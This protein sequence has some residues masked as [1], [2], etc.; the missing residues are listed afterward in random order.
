MSVNLVDGPHTLLYS[1][2]HED[3]QLPIVTKEEHRLGL[4]FQLEF[5]DIQGVELVAQ[6]GGLYV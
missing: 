6:A 4:L 5:W 1:N 3:H 2:H